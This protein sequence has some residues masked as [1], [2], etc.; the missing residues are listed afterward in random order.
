MILSDLTVHTKWYAVSVICGYQVTERYVPLL[1]MALKS[2]KARRELENSDI[3]N[4][5]HGKV[6]LFLGVVLVVFFSRRCPGRCP[7]VHFGHQTA[8]LLKPL[9]VHISTHASS[10]RVK[11]GFIIFKGEAMRLL[12]TNSSKA[13]EESLV[14]FK[15]GLGT[16]KTWIRY[17]KIPVL[18]RI[19]NVM[20]PSRSVTHLH[21]LSF[22]KFFWI[23]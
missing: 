7:K 6:E 20:N 13:C 4:W 16:H 14:T 18:P 12:R 19:C 21:A 9:N 5:I 15:Q 23:S 22:W 10:T 8:N 11:I 17:R 3:L 2:K 1:K